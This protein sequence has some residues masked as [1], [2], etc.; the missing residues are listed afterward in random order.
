L[1]EETGYEARS[2]EFLTEGPSSAGL[3]TEVVSFFWA[4][5]LRRVSEGG[6]DDSENIQVHVVP[7]L[8]LK[9]WLEIKRQEGCLI[10]YKVYTALYFELSRS[11]D[12]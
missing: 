5:G 1:L 6:G 12:K 11:K 10:D 3:A 2:M 4:Q 9:S 8:E 7:L